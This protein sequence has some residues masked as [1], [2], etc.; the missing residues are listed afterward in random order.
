MTLFLYGEDTVGD[1]R[2]IRNAA[3]SALLTGQVVN[4]TSGNTTVQKVININLDVVIKEANE[5]LRLY[6]PSIKA[7]NPIRDITKPYIWY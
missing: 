1:V 3:R 2:E 5:F 6:D 4:W 7:K